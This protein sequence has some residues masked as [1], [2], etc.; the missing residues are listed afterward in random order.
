MMPLPM[1]L[2]TAVLIGWPLVQ[3]ASVLAVR[4]SRAKMRALAAELLADRG[5]SP[6]DRVLLDRSLAE[7]RG[8]TMS[9]I[10]PVALPFA[11]LAAALAELFGRDRPSSSRTTPADV[12][13]RLK[14]LDVQLGL[15]TGDETIDH[16]PRFRELEELAYQV[17]FVRRPVTS[18]LTVFTCLPVL[19][20]YLLA[21]GLR[22]TVAVVPRATSALVRGFRVVTLDLQGA[23]GR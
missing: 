5:H 18:L 7:S 6:S 2:M 22:E 21:Y 3:I 13:A 20:V 10:A 14:K 4:G 8:H 1:I 9:V 23:P 17:G 16:D 19:P 11:L 15:R 12:A